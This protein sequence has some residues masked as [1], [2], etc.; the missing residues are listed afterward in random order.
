MLLHLYLLINGKENQMERYGARNFAKKF[1][2]S[3]AWIKK[4]KAYRRKHPLCERCLKKGIYTPSQCV[5]HK[6]YISRENYKDARITLNDDNLEALCHLCHEREHNGG[7]DYEFDED[8]SL[9]CNYE[10]E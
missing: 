6:I 7:I 9:V 8:G 1:Y 3:S 5:H 10:R 4:S 2:K